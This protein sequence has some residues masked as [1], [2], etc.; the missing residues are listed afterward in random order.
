MK[1]KL[2][3]VL[4]CTCLLTL[5]ILFNAGC[6]KTEDSSNNEPPAPEIPAVSTASV[7]NV[8]PLSASSGG[9][10]I[11]DG[12]ASVTSRGVCWSTAQSPTLT[13]QFTVNGSGPGVFSSSITGLSP[14][15]PYYV[16][17]Y[18]SNSA[19]TAYGNQVNFT[20]GNN[21]A[22]P[23]IQS[24]P[25]TTI[26]QNSAVSGGEITSQGSAAVEA[27]GVCW[28]TSPNPTISGN[29]TND[30][31][32]TGSFTSS[33]TGLAPNTT[34]YLK[35]FATNSV[36]TA[37]ANQITFITLEAEGGQPCPG[38]PTVTYQGETYN[39][40]KIGTQCWF[41]ENLNVGI[42]IDE[43]QLQANNGIIE[44]YCYNDNEA[45]C[46]EYG[47][48]YDWNEM[49]QYVNTEGAKGVC[50]TGWHIPTDSQYEILVGNLGGQA[51]AGG[52]MKETGT[53]HWLAPNTGATN[54]S[55][56]TALPAGHARWYNG[57]F[58]GLGTIS[59]FSTSTHYNLT[60]YWH[61]SVT[62]TLPTATKWGGE[63]TGQSVRCLKD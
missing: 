30:G 40:V 55:G 47:G 6:V 16:R 52:K 22:I 45:N 17:A 42:R 35:A 49:M 53:T 27:R 14:N 29:Y 3:G 33:I 38:I 57:T 11:S 13:D 28:S 62:N 31:S 23:T 58:Y 48:L 2:K 8:T 63:G 32:G 25:V 18:A 4:C 50:P 59:Y 60:S 34:Y 7:T 24:K 51:V 15:T 10:V 56:F 9:N 44:K 37:Y 46:D 19:G 20:T 5:C 43:N 39:T 21:G 54:S 26:T 12:G 1:T 36:G 61:W 41:K